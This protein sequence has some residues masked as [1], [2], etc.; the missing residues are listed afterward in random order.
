MLRH[1]GDQRGPVCCG[2]L[3][4]GRDPHT[5][6]D[7]MQPEIGELLQ[8]SNATA[9]N[10]RASADLDVL[11]VGCGFAGL[12][13]GVRLKENGLN[14]FAIIEEGNDVGGT[15]RD[16]HYPGCACDVPSHL[17]SLSFAPKADWS[18]LYP[19]QGELFTYLRDV[20]DRYG[21]RQH[22][23]FNTAMAHAQWNEHDAL[24]HV[25]TTAGST[26]TAKVLISGVGALH[27]P[28][29]P[30]VPG[31]DKFGGLAFHSLNWP[32]D[33]DLRGKRVA[34]VGAG[35]SAIQ[36]V[37]KV[38]QLAEKLYVFQRTAPWIFP[39][40]D[41]LIGKWERALLRYLPGYRQAFR[42]WLHW[43]HELR[44]LALDN[45]WLLR[46]FEGRARRQIAR[47]ISDPVLRKVVTPNYRMGCKRILLSD[48]YYQ[49]LVQPNVK[50]VS[51]RITALLPNAIITADGAERAIDALIF[52]T[53]FD[54]VDSLRNLQVTGRNGITLRAAWHDAIRAYHGITI[55][56]FPNFFMMLGPN[57]FLGHNSVIMM[58]EA[59]ADYIIDCLKQMAEKGLRVIEVREDAQLK[60]D[61]WLQ[62]RLKGSI[63][64][65]GGC[66]SWY[67]DVSGRNVALWPGFISNYQRG[68]RRMLLS[69]YNV[70]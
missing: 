33:C 56:G 20:A 22:I 40:H 61:E 25:I 65:V 19:S 8:P 24:W 27:V 21:L 62:S 42:K 15:W 52:G 10:T 39:K 66:R 44:M 50:V 32:A 31:L 30:E 59:Q 58:I 48:D 55:A 43:R 54:F 34:V 2:H 12:C 4:A 29:R 70:A 60:F 63:W 7:C 17:Y 37:P 5:G 67:Q 13:M 38:A 36:F 64:Q 49:A 9:P 53:G 26:I 28:S 47:L 35:A 57:T 6:A 23:R 51:E 14:S 11:V 69:D 68:V 16:N 1:T 41:R 45:D 18:R 46:F 3:L